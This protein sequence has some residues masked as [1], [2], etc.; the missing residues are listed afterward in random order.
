VIL[1]CGCDHRIRHYG[2]ARDSSLMAWSIS[3]RRVALDFPDIPARD[4]LND[5]QFI[6]IAA[7]SF[8]GLDLCPKSREIDSG[9]EYDCNPG[10]FVSGRSHDAAD[11]GIPNTLQD[12]KN[13]SR[14]ALDNFT[15]PRLMTSPR[16]PATQRTPSS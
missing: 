14:S 10:L 7:K 1:S 8:I 16:R 3:S 13:S 15:P 4:F 9:I 2:S 6:D 5:E 11:A 12:V